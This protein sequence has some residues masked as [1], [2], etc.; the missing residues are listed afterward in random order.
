[1]SEFLASLDKHDLQIL[2]CACVVIAM[3]AML[4]FVQLEK[5]WKR[6]KWRHPKC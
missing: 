1:M 6:R 2:A 4:A 3:G 5:I